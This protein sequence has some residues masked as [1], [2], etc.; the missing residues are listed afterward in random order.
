M[1]TKPRTEVKGN[2]RYPTVALSVTEGR[3]RADRYRE[4]G[5]EARG[6]AE[7][8]ENLGRDL[9]DAAVFI[10]AAGVIA[11]TVTAQPEIVAIGIITA[12]LGEILDRAGQDMNKQADEAD[13][14]AG[15]IERKEQE[16]EPPSPPEKEQQ[17]AP[18]PHDSRGEARGS[19]GYAGPD[20]PDSFGN[21]A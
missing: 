1:L 5:N 19:G 17:Q 12:E 14:R 20:H 11:G 13:R 16:K 21:V 7:H 15:E 6:R 3:S 8:L 10:S 4:F 9:K 18:G 2:V